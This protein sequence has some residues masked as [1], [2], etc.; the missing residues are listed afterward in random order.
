MDKKDLVNQYKNRIQIG[1]VFAIK[2]TMIDKWHVDCAADLA[3]AKN[4]FCFM[5][6]SYMKIAKDYK[7][8]NGEGFE[9]DVLEELQKGETQTDKEF[10]ADLALLKSLWL[11]KLDGHGQVMY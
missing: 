8:Q 10:Q 1:G 9:F 4:R 7:E 2:N 11:E 6:D 5:G 3:A